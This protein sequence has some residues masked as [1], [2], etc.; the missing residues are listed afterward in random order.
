MCAGASAQVTT[1]T[2]KPF[3][4]ELKPKLHAVTT[5]RPAA[6]KITVEAGRR[7][8]GTATL[9]RPM[10]AQ[11]RKAPLTTDGKLKLDEVIMTNPDGSNA[12][13]ECYEYNDK[14]KEIRRKTYYWDTMTQSWG[15]PAM[16][17]DY[18]W[19]EDGLILVEQVTSGSQGVRYEYKYNDKGLGIEQVTSELGFNGKWTPVS[20]GEYAYDDNAN[21]IDELLCTWDGMQWVN[22]TH[23]QATWDGK[24]RQTSFIGYAWDGTSWQGTGNDVYEW[25]DGPRD[26]DYI[27]GSNPERMTYKGESLW[28][29][30]EWHLYYKFINEFNTEGRIAGQSELY[31]NRTLNA[32]CGGDTWDGLVYNPLSWYGKITYDDH[33]AQTLSETWKYL[34]DNSGVISLG[35]SPTVWKYDDE[36][37][38]VGLYKFVQNIYNENN[39]KIDEKVS[40][41]THYA[42]NA[43]NKCTWVREQL[44]NE[45]GSTTDLFEEKYVYNEQGLQTISA[46]WDWVDGKRTPTSWTE[47]KYNA[48]G[49]PVE[50]I[51]KSGDSGLSPLGAP[52]TRGAEIEPD[53]ETGWVNASRW[54]YA[55][56]NGT[57]IEKLGYRWA[58]GEWT[59]NNGQTVEY[60]FDVTPDEF[61]KPEGWTDP[62]KINRVKNYYA[63]GYNGWLIST[64]TYYYSEAL[65]SG[66]GAV[67]A[68]GND[69]VKVSYADG[70]LHISAD[71][72]VTVNI[73]GA[74]GMLARS[75]AE[76]TVYVGD[77]PAGLYI[78]TVNGYSTKFIKE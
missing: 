24:N 70:N 27:E 68:G 66:I 52:A 61:I 69:D 34:P 76:K 55:Y 5:E 71:G 39:E 6:G 26:P 25:F 37:N 53:D 3:A 2:D 29:N 57:L 67:N 41:Q 78:V 42:Y 46:V 64:N 32:W 59:T 74:G 45:D 50:L 15:S 21:I 13:K 43:D 7:G 28:I 44:V 23:N 51:T 10:A 17:Y 12:Q 38:R 60:D 36:G 72:N 31:Y 47:Y 19:S 18:T 73:Y 65:P 33:G 54:T 75:A 49:L 35:A 63:D 58:N 1:G 11:A 40:Q 14:G 8:T 22:N 9:V 62:Y 30:G 77:M 48:E 20:K 16:Q 56:E 4:T